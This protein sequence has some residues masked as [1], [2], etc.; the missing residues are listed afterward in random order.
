MFREAGFKHV[1]IS[2]SVK[3]KSLQWTA[4]MMFIESLLQKKET[5]HEVS[6]NYIFLYLNL[7]YFQTLKHWNTQS[8]SLTVDPATIED[9]ATVQQL[10]E[11]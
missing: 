6:F 2:F 1:I 10:L 7:S 3:Y 8:Q 5:K 9:S 4:Q 11:L